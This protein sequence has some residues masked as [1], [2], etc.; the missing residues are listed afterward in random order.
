MLGWK[1]KLRIKIQLARH[2]GVAPDDLGDYE[3]SEI[4]CLCCHYT[5]F[6]VFHPDKWSP[7][8]TRKRCPRCARM[9]GRCVVAEDAIF[10][11]NEDIREDTE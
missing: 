1:D 10:G 11:V 2:K 3:V 4:I 8:G 7:V 5:W 6:G 9:A